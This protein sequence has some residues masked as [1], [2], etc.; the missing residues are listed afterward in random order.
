MEDF[1]F[2]TLSTDALKV[3][4]HRATHSGL[5]HA[6]QTIPRDPKPGQPV[7]IVV[8]T[9]PDV[10][11][12]EIACYF[13]TNGEDPAGSRGKSETSEVIFLKKVQVKWDSLKWG[14]C[15]RWEGIIPGLPLGTQVRY[16]ISG[17]R[18]NSEEIL[19]DWPNAKETVEEA[20]KYYF[21]HKAVPK[22]KFEGDPGK[23]NIF[24]YY[25]DNLKP[26]NWAKEA[27]FYHIF[28]DRFFPGNEQ[29]W[30]QVKDLKKQ[31]GGTLWGVRDKLEYI[32]NLGANA[33]W[34]SPI[35]PSPSIHRYDATD[36]KHVADELGGDEAL[37]VLIREAHDNGIRV[38]LDLVC[39]HISNQHPKFIDARS[40]PKS[41]YR[42]WFTFDHKDKI[43][44]RTYFGVHS[45]PR[46]NLNNPNARAWM[47]GIAQYWLENYK[48]D[49]FRLDHANGPDPEFWGEFW[50][51]CKAI[52]PESF[53]I[54]EV[55]EPPDVMAQYEGRMDGLLDFQLCDTIR[56]AVNS[57]DWSE[58]HLIHFCK[59]HEGFFQKEFLLATFLDNHDMNRFLFTVNNDINKLKAAAKLQFN[60]PGPPII[61]Y[62]TEIGIRQ[63][64]SNSSKVGLEASRGRMVW[65]KEQDQDLLEFYRNL[66]SER[67]KRK[68]WESRLT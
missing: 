4:Y 39:N 47:L 23:G 40:N 16:K 8:E 27:V 15:Q 57:N 17:W 66:I 20:A 30:I 2:G 67:K 5:R 62:G 34:L 44:Y 53:Y 1:I 7:K 59:D 42:N 10:F 14:Y 26:P 60:L 9:G 46:V 32:K 68:P 43:G 64:I 56:R 55:V 33:I 37:T 13:S 54:G 50:Q 58:E 22:I 11:I 48:V 12:D 38:I 29:D 63:A 6:F 31:F 61:Y 51:T 36:Y 28:V 21:K 35:F 18:G 52:R 49:G 25:V 24:S 41:P 45:M 3:I 19:A 65:G